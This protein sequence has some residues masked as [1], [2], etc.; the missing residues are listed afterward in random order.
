MEEL[1]KMS[2]KAETPLDDLFYSIAKRTVLKNPE[3]RM[4]MDEIVA[5]FEKFFDNFSS[6]E[7][8]QIDEYKAFINDPEYIRQGTKEIAPFV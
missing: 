3:E 4:T 7:K 6:D 8:K 2:D 5:E 1:D